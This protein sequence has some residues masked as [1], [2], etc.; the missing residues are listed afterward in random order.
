LLKRLSPWADCLLWLLVGWLGIFTPSLFLVALIRNR[1][2]TAGLQ[3]YLGFL[4]N[5]IGISLVLLLGLASSPSSAGEV[6]SLRP[7][8]W[9]ALPAVGLST[10]GLSLLGAEMDTRLSEWFPP[11]DWVNELFRR[12]LEYHSPGEFLGVFAFLVVVAPVTEELLFRGLFLHRLREGHGS[13][14]AVLGSALC[15][16][17]FHLIPWQAVGAALVGIY[18]GY[19][20]VR[21]RSILV[22]IFAHASFNLVPV[23]ASGLASTH[24]I[25]RR[26]APDDSQ[27]PSRLPAVWLLAASLAFLAGLFWIQR[28][29]SPPAAGDGSLTPR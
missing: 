2:Q 29:T 24:P 13:V 19:L 20:L 3:I 27:L 1:P 23:L 8:L 5:L 10:L 7:P 4:P 26:L 15:F 9:S 18:L 11:P 25:L 12:A 22:S 14:H 21:T 28:L 6:L 17:V 16:G